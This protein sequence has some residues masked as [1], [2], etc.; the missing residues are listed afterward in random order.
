M[1]RVCPTCQTM[2]DTTAAVF[3]AGVVE[4]EHVKTEQPITDKSR[5]KSEKAQSQEPKKI[6]Q[7]NVEE[8]K[9]ADI[10]AVEDRTISPPK[11]IEPKILQPTTTDP[12]MTDSKKTETKTLTQ[13]E[14]MQARAAETKTVMPQKVLEPKILQPKTIEP[15]TTT[16]PEKL[17]AKTTESK[18]IVPT[19]IAVPSKTA[20]HKTT[21]P[22]TIVKQT[23]KSEGENASSG[24]TCQYYYGYLGQREKGEGIPNSCVECAKSLDCMLA[25]YYKSKET[26]EEIRKWY[27]PKF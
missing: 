3:Q 12:E 10:K 23:V 27:H 21:E 13:P 4:E 24:N 19:L 11:T 18:T 5:E 20:E 7:P 14:T 2:I 25:E 8:T 6:I 22:K 17:E 9:K 16:Q 1:Y 26:V 15:K